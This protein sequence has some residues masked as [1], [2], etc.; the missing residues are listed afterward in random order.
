MRQLALPLTA[1]VVSFGGCG[2][3]GACG[4]G[5][6]AENG[7]CVPVCSEPCGEHAFCDETPQGGACACATGY[8]GDP[9]EWVGVLADPEFTDP[10]VWSDT[11]NGATVIP[12][13][14]GRGN[15][16]G[17]ASFQ[18][19]VT[20]SAGSVAQVVEMPSYELAEPLVVTIS[21]RV[22]NVTGVV[23][24][25]GGVFRELIDAARWPGWSVD[26]RVCLG[27]AAY[28]GPVRFEV[29]ASERAPDCFTAPTGTIEVDRFDIVPANPGECPAPGTVLDG[30]AEGL[31]DGWQFDLQ[32]LGEGETEA[33]LATGAGEGASSGARIRKP[34]GATRRARMWTKISVPRQ[35]TPPFPALRFWH[36]AAAPYIYRVDLG[37][38]PSFGVVRMP[39]DT[40]VGDDIARTSTFCLPPHT[41][42]GVFDLAFARGSGITE[43]EAEL[44]VDRVEITSDDA[45]GTSSE[46][47][48]PSLD[49][50]PNRW[51]GA[52]LSFVPNV[53]AGIVQVTNDAPEALPPGS[54]V[55]EIRYTNSQARLEAQTWVRVPAPTAD[56]GPILRFQS[57]APANPGVELFWALGSAIDR[58]VCADLPGCVVLS[59]LSNG[60]DLG[61]GWRDVPVCLPPEW[62]GR[63]FRV[64]LA[65]RPSD[66]PLEVFE[67]PRSVLFDNFELDTDPECPGL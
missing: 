50:A 54:G 61:G 38:R 19:S 59:P 25:Y 4:T 34:P 55:L 23:V 6:A 43:D 12:L 14:Q 8:A 48:D 53:E 63:W 41:H 40:I 66:G 27:E 51:P 35:T 62:A 9:C 10:E 57:N 30:D 22:Q 47:F 2:D 18:A 1:L 42:G 49:S 5:F 15:E 17:I 44:V 65:V 37:T 45:C 3:A 13:A 16:L 46:V 39:L 64:R 11:K 7:R 36:K 56:E 33:G 60:L 28:G 26:Q 24:G 52:L 58:P 67:P 20:C 21:Y 32:M 31:E 29:A